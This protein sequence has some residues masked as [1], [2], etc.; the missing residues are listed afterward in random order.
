MN[1]N[2]L[3]GLRSGLLTA[4]LFWVLRIPLLTPFILP[5]PMWTVT[6]V[7]SLQWT[8]IL[9]VL[10]ERHHTKGWLLW[11]LGL[12]HIL[13]C[14]HPMWGLE[15]QSQVIC[16]QSNLQVMCLW[17]QLWLTQEISCCLPY[18]IWMVLQTPGFSQHSSVLGIGRV[19]QQMEDLPFSFSYFSFLALYHLT[20]NFSY[21]S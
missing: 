11:Q 21:E 17:T 16:F 2:T 13:G 1:Y 14:Q 18:E 7:Y 6:S 20:S 10:P 8:L 15:F 3:R 9:P 4:L 12:S 19:D 5:K